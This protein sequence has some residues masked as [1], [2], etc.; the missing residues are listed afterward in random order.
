MEARE[1]AGRRQPPGQVKLKNTTTNL[2]WHCLLKKSRKFSTINFSRDFFAP[3]LLPVISQREFL[4]EVY[5]FL[6]APAVLA[7]SLTVG[8]SL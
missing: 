8:L 5:L 6:A 2:A 7:K 3:F 4:T 1:A